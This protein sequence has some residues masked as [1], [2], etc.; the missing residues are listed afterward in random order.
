MTRL[1]AVDGAEFNTILAALRF[2]Q[3]QGQGEPHNRSD[4]IHEIATDGGADTSL[5]ANAIDVL[6]ERINTENL[7]SKGDRAIEIVREAARQWY[8]VDGTSASDAL[9]E[10][11]DD[12][13]HAGIFT[14]AEVHQWCEEET[15]E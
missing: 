1:I 8:A 5:D 3:E 4:A 9:D 15:E 10:L 7:S 14:V 13:C 6:C 12:A 11:C 2:Y